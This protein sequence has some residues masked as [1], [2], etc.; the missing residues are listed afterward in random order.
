MS[1]P[2]TNDLNIND[3]NTDNQGT[4]PV[5]SAGELP[6]DE[7]FRQL[8]AAAQAQ[9]PYLADALSGVAGYQHR[10]AAGA[11]LQHR[12]PGLWLGGHPQQR[13]AH[14]AGAQ[15]GRGP[16]AQRGRRRRARTMAHWRKPLPTTPTPLASLATPF[17]KSAKTCC[18]PS[19]LMA[20][21]LR[22]NRWRQRKRGSSIRW[23][24]R[25]LSTPRRKLWR[26]SPTWRIFSPTTLKTVNGVIE[27][28]GYFPF[29]SEEPRDNLE[30]LRQR[31]GGRCGGGRCG[32]GGGRNARTT[33]S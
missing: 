29:V 18:V 6:D 5:D 23:R 10:C 19:L 28:V 13:G 17:S 25:S 1:D 30:T 2:N 22:L 4:S 8:G 15:R 16:H 21:H 11:A 9:G 24:A 7:A 33:A 31:G 26:A 27:A 32:G 12:Q 20:F 14:Y 3:Q